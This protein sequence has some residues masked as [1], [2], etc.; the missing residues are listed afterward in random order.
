MQQVAAHPPVL[1]ARSAR[2]LFQNYEDVRRPVTA[3]RLHKPCDSP[4]AWSIRD[5]NERIREPSTNGPRLCSHQTQRWL[6]SSLRFV[7]PW[8]C[9]C[10]AGST[11]FLDDAVPE[12][13]DLVR[14][15]PRNGSGAGR[16][17]MPLAFVK[18]DSVNV[19]R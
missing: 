9:R 13:A 12:I 7:R 17:R 19:A 8:R 6:D 2:R 15:L 10:R 18:K 3:Y 4:L 14:S 5:L 16:E 11:E 1:F